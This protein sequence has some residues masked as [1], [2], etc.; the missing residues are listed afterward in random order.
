MTRIQKINHW[1]PIVAGIVADWRRLDGACDAAMK[2]GCMDPEGPLHDAIWR[3]FQGMLERVDVDGW[4]SWFI[5]DNGC[6]SK[7]AE[8][9]G[10][11]KRG[12]RPI[13][14]E[15]DLAVL[16]VASIEAGADATP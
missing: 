10:C 14:T 15:R 1:Q 6:G 9:K 5:Y 8:A 3:S 16:I 13:K 4:I 2:A 12:M 7:G 11:G